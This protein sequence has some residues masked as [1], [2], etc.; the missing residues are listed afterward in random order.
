MRVKLYLMIVTTCLVMA[1]LG[2]VLT[3]PETAQAAPGG[4]KGNGGKVGGDVSGWIFSKVKFDDGGSVISDDFTSADNPDG[5]YVDGEDRTQMRIGRNRNILMDFNTHNKKDSIRTLVFSGGFPAPVLD[6]VTPPILSGG[7]TT[8]PSGPGPAIGSES[9]AKDAKLVIK[10]E[11]H[12]NSPV[13][14]EPR[15]ENAVLTVKDDKDETWIVHFGKDVSG[16]GSEFAPDGDW[17]EVTRL[18]NVDGKSLWTFS[19]TGLG[20]VYRDNNPPHSPTEFWGVVT[21]PFSGT[22]ESLTDEPEP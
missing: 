9:A 20:Y 17:I 8:T 2:T 10:G 19:T 12:D 18:P 14:P 3:V 6:G 1:A 11:D 15:R 7:P 22:I 21:I 4:G 13:D 5:W 16:G